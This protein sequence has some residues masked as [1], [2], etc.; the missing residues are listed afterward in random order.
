MVVISSI[1]RLNIFKKIYITDDICI[2]L[3][4]K[5]NNDI[6]IVIC[7]Y[8]LGNNN[9]RIYSPYMP[10]KLTENI[11]K[12]KFIFEKPSPPDEYSYF[13][14]RHDTRV[15]II[16]DYCKYLYL[17]YGYDNYL[18]LKEFI[19][20]L[21]LNNLKPTSLPEGVIK[22]LLKR[23][24]YYKGRFSYN[25]YKIDN[26]IEIDGYNGLYLELF[27]EINYTYSKYEYEIKHVFLIDSDY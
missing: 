2:F 9:S 7:E 19:Y 10:K 8:I 3:D 27:R 5:F 15:K 18:Y 22:L 26:N 20:L 6:Q 17:K 25:Y 21:R 16:W 11:L 4:N 12:N 13:I 1:N 24:E 23:C 14:H